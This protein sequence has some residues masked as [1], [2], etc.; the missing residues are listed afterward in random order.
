MLN[1]KH[2]FWQALV[3]ALIIFFMGIMIG[4]I[5]ENSRIDQM[6]ETY[7]KSETDF[8]DFDL[9]SK[10]IY[11]NNESCKIIKNE[12]VFFADKIYKEA[13]KLGKYEDSNKITTEQIALHKR[14]DL[15]RTLLWKRIIENKK[16][17]DSKFNTVVYFYQYKDP[18]LELKVLQG[19]M[20]NFLFDLKEKYEENIILLPIATDT[21]VES[22]KI[23]MKKY[24]VKK[25]PSILI[26]EK[27]VV[28]NTDSLEKVGKYLI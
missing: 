20:S 16:N 15:L 19:T 23:L 13:V 7:F 28:E 3:V 11:E 2:T 24:N 8:F 9:S 6:K 5:F 17:C 26:N 4:V 27:F 12:S 18:S 10:I 22:L 1:N 14:Y 25:V 21:N